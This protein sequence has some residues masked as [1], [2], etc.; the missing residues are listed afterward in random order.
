GH[1]L[2]LRQMPMAHQPRPA[3]G[4]QLVGVVAEKACNL[5]LYSVRQQ[6]SRAIA[7]NLCQRI[8]E[9]PWLGELDHIILGHG[10][11][12]LWWRS[13][14]FRTPPRSAA[15][16]PLHPVTNFRAQLPAA[17]GPRRGGAL[18]GCATRPPR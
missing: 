12:L 9:S 3:I 1:D 15:A 11:S 8:A 2:A 5:G 13:G 7:Q 10:V 18:R 17:G 4:S 14:G 16:L 6:R